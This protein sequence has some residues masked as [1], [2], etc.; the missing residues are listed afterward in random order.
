MST[1]SSCSY[2]PSQ[3]EGI[4]KAKLL[5]ET[6]FTFEHLHFMYLKM[7]KNGGVGKTEK[8]FSSDWFY[9]SIYYDSSLF[10]F[11]QKSINFPRVVISAGCFSIWSLCLYEQYAMATEESKKE[12][13]GEKF[14]C[15]VTVEVDD[16][17]IRKLLFREHVLAAHLGYVE[18]QRVQRSVNNVEMP[19][20]TLPDI[21]ASVEENATK[22]CK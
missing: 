18:V 2:A 4:Y 10:L 11:R 9:W 16:W 7:T 21:S 13:K 20:Q 22:L 5:F 8:T 14:R 15:W 19:A 17:Q 3:D 1:T 12:A 6:F